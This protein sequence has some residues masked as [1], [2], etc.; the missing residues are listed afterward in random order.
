MTD[1]FWQ[2]IRYLL[3]A[4]GFYLAGRGIVDPGKVM[5]HVELAMNILPGLVGLAAA[6][7]GFFVKWRTKTVPE[8]TGD[9]TD[10]P[11]VNTATG[12]VEPASQPV[13]LYD[14]DP[15]PRR[16]AAPNQPRKMKKR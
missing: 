12:A 16:W 14:P 7:W 9:R 3:I 5:T 4:G 13:S 10:V 11:T 2:G 8:E 6:G 15:V 1:N